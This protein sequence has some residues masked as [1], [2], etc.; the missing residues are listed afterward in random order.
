MTSREKI[1]EAWAVWDKLVARDGDPSP[2]AQL[3]DAR[4]EITLRLRTILPNKKGFGSQ[5]P[6]NA[7]RFDHYVKRTT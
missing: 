5:Y 4:H 3:V 6:W 2:S 1:K 7:S